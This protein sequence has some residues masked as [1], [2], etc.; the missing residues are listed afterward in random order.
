[1]GAA[2]EPYWEGRLCFR[3]PAGRDS[4]EAHNVVAQSKV[5]AGSCKVF[6]MDLRQ[7]EQEDHAGE[8]HGEQGQVRLG[9]RGYTAC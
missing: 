9:T 3:R 7:R 1:M 5:F 6:W 4:H 8:Q 2:V